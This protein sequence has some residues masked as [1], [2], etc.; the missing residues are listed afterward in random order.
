MQ[1]FVFRFIRFHWSYEEQKFVPTRY[2]CE[3]S[4]DSLRDKLQP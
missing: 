2:D 1:M 4:Y 3:L